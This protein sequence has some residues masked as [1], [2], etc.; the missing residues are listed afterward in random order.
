MAIGIESGNSGLNFVSFDVWKT[1]VRSNPDFKPARAKLVADKIGTELGLVEGAIRNA[2]VELDKDTDSSGLQHGPEDRL[3]AT[4][5]SLGVP[6]SDI[7]DLSSELSDEVQRLFL[8]YPPELNEEGLLETLSEISNRVNGI[9]IIS[10]TGFI[11]GEYMRR[12]LESIGLMRHVKKAIFS[13]EEGLAKPDRRIFNRVIEDSDCIDNPG[14]IVHVGDNQS[15]DYQGA[16][17][18]GMSAVLLS[19]IDHPGG[20]ASAPTIRAALDE[21]ILC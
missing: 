6:E 3:R 12:A 10:N 7:D 19:P 13:D 2:D 17:R 16:L 21:G 20:Y 8:G 9:Y 5:L 11:N 18:V 15:A 14:R 1:L 4:F